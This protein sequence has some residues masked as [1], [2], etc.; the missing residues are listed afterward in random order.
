MHKN[1]RYKDSNGQHQFHKLTLMFVHGDGMALHELGKFAEN[2]SNVTVIS[3][4]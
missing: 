2:D 3:S 1:M 4:P